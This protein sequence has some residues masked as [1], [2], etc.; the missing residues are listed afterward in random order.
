M[1]IEN[2]C[3][4]LNESQIKILEDTYSAKYVFESCI[5]GPKGNWIN[6]PFAIFYTEVAHPEGSNYF[7][8]FTG[9]MNQ[10]FIANAITATEV[11]YTGIL[12]ENNTV[13]YSRFRHDYCDAK[14][15][16]IDGGRDY[17]RIVG[18]PQTARFK[19]VKDKLENI[20]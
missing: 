7:G 13:I 16:A 17:M 11:E 6:C 5:R 20:E 9:S 4:F 8:I 18:N 15:G 3:S 10:L 1:K 19:V 2:E 14:S 12:T